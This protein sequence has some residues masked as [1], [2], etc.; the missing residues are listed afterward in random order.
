MR[1]KALEVVFCVPS[2]IK[3]DLLGTTEKEKT[4]LSHNVGHYDIYNQ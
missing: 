2:L 1:S 3:T 4:Y